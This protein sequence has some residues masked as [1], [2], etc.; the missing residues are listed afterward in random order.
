MQFTAFIFKMP[1]KYKN[2]ISLNKKLQIIKVRGI[3]KANTNIS[4]SLTFWQLL[5]NLNQSYT[6]QQYLHPPPL[7]IPKVCLK[8]ESWKAE[9]FNTWNSPLTGINLGVNLFFPI[10]KPKTFF[11]PNRLF[12]YFFCGSVISFKNGLSN[13]L[14]KI[15]YT[16]LT[17]VFQ[18]LF[19]IIMLR[20]WQ[21]TWMLNPSAEAAF[22]PLMLCLEASKQNQEHPNR[23]SSPFGLV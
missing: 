9:T 22:H 15:Y 19:G 20:A 18:T 6:T 16:W 12:K 14:M 7:R 5:K 17:Y 1:K 23:R 13:L 8:I 4:I 11:S 10:K 3:Q 2:R 21:P